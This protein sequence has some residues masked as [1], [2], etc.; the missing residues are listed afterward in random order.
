MYDVGNRVAIIVAVTFIVVAIGVGIWG[1]THLMQDFRHNLD[2][3]PSNNWLENDLSKELVC[4]VRVLDTAQKGN[5]LK[6]RCVAGGIVYLATYEVQGG[7]K[8]WKIQDIKKLEV[9]KCHI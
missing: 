8:Y 3:P 2:N 6:V 4:N 5:Q 1:W 9:T 7:W